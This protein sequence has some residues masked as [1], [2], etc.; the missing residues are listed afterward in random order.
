M[1]I[2]EADNALASA[3]LVVRSR[4]RACIA[5]VVLKNGIIFGAAL[6]DIESGI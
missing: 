3:W 6:A 4:G 2:S 1:S 5:V